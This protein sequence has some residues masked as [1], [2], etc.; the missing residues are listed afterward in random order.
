MIIRGGFREMQDFLHRDGAEWD[1]WGSLAREQRFALKHSGLILSARAAVFVLLLRPTIREVLCQN[2]VAELNPLGSYVT[3]NN[4]LVD[5]DAVG[6]REIGLQVNIICI[7][8]FPGH[9]HRLTINLFDYFSRVLSFFAPAGKLTKP[10]QWVSFT[11][12]SKGRHRSFPAAEFG[13]IN[14]RR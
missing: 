14:R 3:E 1:D 8:Q 10:K 4:V 11:I 7:G 12:F 2:V 6:D 9:S 13:T 5:E